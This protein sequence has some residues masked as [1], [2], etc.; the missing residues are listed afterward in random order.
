MFWKWSPNRFGWDSG[1][2]RAVVSKVDQLLHIDEPRSL[3]DTN[4]AA[5][6]STRCRCCSISRCR[7]RRRLKV[8]Q[9]FM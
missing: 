2:V 1:V 8:F 3:E 5:G 4:G 9:A 6:Y 7:T